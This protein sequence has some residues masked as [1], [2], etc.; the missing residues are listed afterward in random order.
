MGAFD[1]FRRL[2]RPRPERPAPPSRDE[3]VAERFGQPE[4][5]PDP[6][7][8]APLHCAKCGGDNPARSATCFN[9]GADL[10][11]PEMRAQQEAHRE[12]HLESQRRALME[13]EARK[14]EALAA[15][16]RELERRRHAA[17]APTEP[18]PTDFAGTWNAP[19]L[20]LFRWTGRIADPSLRLAAQVAL[21][22]AFIALVAYAISGPSRYG[23]LVLIAILLGGGTG[24]RYRRWWW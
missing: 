23:L 18:T 17:T 14:R 9:C 20:S 19:I 7:D 10:D 16:E 2:E 24:R 5:P 4:I 8:A 21:A 12:R 6:A 1:R 15:A 3:S 13:R 11:T 22:G